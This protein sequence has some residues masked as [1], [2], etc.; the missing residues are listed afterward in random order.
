MRARRLAAPMVALLLLTNSAAAAQQAPAP[1]ATFKHLQIMDELRSERFAFG[2]LDS[3]AR[4]FGLHGEENSWSVTDGSRF[5]MLGASPKE[6]QVVLIL[7][8]LDD[9]DA[10]PAEIV[11]A[12]IQKSTRVDFARD[13][14]NVEFPPETYAVGGRR[15]TVTQELDFDLSQWHLQSTLMRYQWAD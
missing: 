7:T 8:R 15:L 4:A 14:L 6:Q 3:L 9:G 1:L 12:L 10:V 11:A 2:R 5:V 13:C